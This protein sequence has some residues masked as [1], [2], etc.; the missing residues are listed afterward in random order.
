MLQ[1]ISKPDGSRVTV[2]P[3]GTRLSFN[4]V[5]H[6][7]CCCSDYGVLV[8]QDGVRVP[9]SPA[10]PLPFTNIDFD[11]HV[12]LVVRWQLRRPLC[13]DA[14][15][16]WH[17]GCS[18]PNASNPSYLDSGASNTIRQFMEHGDQN[19][20]PCSLLTAVEELHCQRK[21]YTVR[22][23]CQIPEVVIATP[24]VRLNSA[25][26]RVITPKSVAVRAC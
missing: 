8:A 7:M 26:C 6:S 20:H 17:Q 13:T 25:E 4:K 16:I 18:S 22:N 9:I 5:Q 24:Q 23:W 11:E 19:W 2:F 14:C 15:L 12:A 3:D 1:V 10:G 21:R